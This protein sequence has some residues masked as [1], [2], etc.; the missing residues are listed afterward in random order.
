MRYR[1]KAVEIEAVVFTYPITDELLEFAGPSLGTCRKNRHPSA[2]AELEVLTL[3]DG[4]DLKVTHIATEGDYI[5]K[6]VQG[7]FY[8]C[9]PGIFVLTYDKVD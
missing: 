1:K 9:K 2:I 4:K 8:P 7:E 3:E 5:I 6:G